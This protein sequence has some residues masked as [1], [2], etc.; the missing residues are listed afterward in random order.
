MDRVGGGGG[1]ARVVDRNLTGSRKRC[2][3][4]WSPKMVWFGR[5]ATHNF[6]NMVGYFSTIEKISWTHFLQSGKFGIHLHCIS[7][8]H[9]V[10]FSVCLVCKNNIVSFQLFNMRSRK[11][12]NIWSY[13]E[14]H[15]FATSWLLKAQNMSDSVGETVLASIQIPSKLTQNIPHKNTCTG[16]SN[17]II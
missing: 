15:G 5:N 8:L 11:G 14:K 4:N 10:T 2:A 13:M 6:C 3:W 17:Q 9:S 16:K 7:P 1:F 12:G